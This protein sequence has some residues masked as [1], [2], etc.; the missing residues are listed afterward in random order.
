M[1]TRTSRYRGYSSLQFEKTGSFV[2]TDM[3]LIKSDLINHIFTRKGERVMMPTFGT[4]IPDLVFE[5]LDEDLV[6]IVKDELETVFNFD[7]RVSIVALQVEPIF[8]QN[9]I[10]VE[11]RL[12]YIELNVVGD[13]NFNII[14]NE[15]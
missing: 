10:Y 5:P 14:F 1:A 9:A 4:E 13:F 11:A 6:E 8:K 12:R 15:G 7:P 3:D 2:L